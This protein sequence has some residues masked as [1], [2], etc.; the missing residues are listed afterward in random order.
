MLGYTDVA[1]AAMQL[2][3]EG[4]TAFEDLVGGNALK[5]AWF[6]NSDRYLEC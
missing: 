5:V 3:I 1:F 4:R 6:E 2:A